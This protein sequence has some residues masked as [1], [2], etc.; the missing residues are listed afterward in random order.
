MVP[1][2]LTQIPLFAS[3]SKF[4]DGYLGRTLSGEILYVRPRRCVGDTITI[5]RHADFEFHSKGAITKI[6]RRLGWA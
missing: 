1:G 3:T 4:R 6:A 5:L 2:M